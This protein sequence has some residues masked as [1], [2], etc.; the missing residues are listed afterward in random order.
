MALKEMNGYLTGA[1]GDWRLG[2]CA[3]ASPGRGPALNQ[4]VTRAH[5]DRLAAT[6]DENW[7][8]SPDYVHWMTGCMLARLRPGGGDVVADIGCGTGLYARG[9][10][11][12]VATVV[13]VDA[14]EAML[15]QL[16]ADERL[17][18][19]HARVEDVAAGRVALPRSPFDAM[20]LKEMLHH[21]SD[22]AAVIAGLAG[23]LRPGGRMLV[24]QLPSRISYPLFPAA[25]ALFESRQ[26]A[27]ESIA[28][29]MREAGLTADVTYEGFPLVFETGRYLR[30]V[31]DRYMS[32]LAAF[33]DEELAAGVAQIRRDHPGERISFRDTFAFI[34]GVAS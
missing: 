28:Q 23:L 18:T 6:F 26:P 10:A 13:C 21:T 31:G 16:P 19:V 30:M 14:S 29:A 2:H 4:D 7:A 9:L 27:P 11:E 22:R 20:L 1:G 33:G 3:A 12:H 34:M 17:V 15:A 25:L 32:L 24:V 8:H 5:Y